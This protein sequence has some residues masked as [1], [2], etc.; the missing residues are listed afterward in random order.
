M[1]IEPQH[2]GIDGIWRLFGDPWIAMLAVGGL[3][4]Q[5]NNHLLMGLGYWNIFLVV[6]II[7]CI[8]PLSN[9]YQK[10]TLGK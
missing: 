2:P 6:L 3:G 4:H 10:I 1:K 8:A 5:L 7:D 9:R